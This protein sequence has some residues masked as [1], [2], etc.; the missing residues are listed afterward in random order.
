MMLLINLQFLSEASRRS[1]KTRAALF[2]FFKP[3]PLFL[4]PLLCHLVTSQVTHP[5]HQCVSYFNNIN[6]LMPQGSFFII[7]FWFLVTNL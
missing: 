2:Q 1:F 4:L 7:C 3:L 6:T 5:L